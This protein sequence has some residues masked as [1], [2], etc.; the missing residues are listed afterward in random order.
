MSARRNLI[1]LITFAGPTAYRLLRKYGPEIRQALQD[2]PKLVDAVKE[3]VF[4]AASSSRGKGRAHQ[5]SERI[6]VLREQVVYLYGTANSPQVARQAKRWRTEL[7]SIEKSAALLN[8]MSNKKRFQTK[9]NLQTRLDDLSQQILQ[10]T[11]A[12]HIEDAELIED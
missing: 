2:N 4:N 3:R 9:R 8:A 1:R 11:L 6:K 12:D 10:M 5:L 7:D